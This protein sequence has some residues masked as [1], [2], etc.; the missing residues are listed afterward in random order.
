MIVPLNGVSAPSSN[1]PMTRLP[2]VEAAG[3]ALAAAD[4]EGAAEDAAATDGAVDGAPPVHAARNAL[5]PATPPIAAP[6]RSRSRRVMRRYRTLSSLTGSLLPTEWPAA[7]RP[8][9]PPSS[10]FR[11]RS[12]PLPDR[13]SRRPGRRSGPSSLVRHEPSLAH[14]R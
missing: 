4:A 8:D 11:R 13:P 10:R 12:R 5:A 6:R 1:A 9:E 14:H 2:P 3:L 7:R